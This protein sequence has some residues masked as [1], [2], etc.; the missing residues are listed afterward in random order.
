MGIP[1]RDFGGYPLQNAPEWTVSA[2]YQHEFPV[3]PGRL[4]ARLE[5]RYEDSFWGTFAQ[6]R[7][8][9]QQDYF[10]TDASVTYYAP[11]DRWSLGLWVK[12]I[13]NEAVLAAA[14]TGQYGPYA[15]VFIEP[16]RTFGARFTF[17]L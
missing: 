5:M 9:E 7:G 17:R 11:D 15:D 6:F 10:K 14:T 1:N 16:P 8:T 13:E 2:G 12:N 3:G 4:L